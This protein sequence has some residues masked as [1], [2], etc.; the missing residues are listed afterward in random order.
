MTYN[1]TAKREAAIV[2]ALHTICRIDDACDR[3]A[4]QK[5][6]KIELIKK[7][8]L[9]GLEK[10]DARKLIQRALFEF[11][12]AYKNQLQHEPEGDAVTDWTPLADSAFA[13][14]VTR[15]MRETDPE[16]CDVAGHEDKPVKLPVKVPR[17]LQSAITK[18]VSTYTPAQIKEALKRVA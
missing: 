3:L 15:R 12:P 7:E 6:E 4:E 2:D 13:R 5:D 10:G 16:R 8:R 1:L 9:A 18:L 14:N 17:E 11:Y